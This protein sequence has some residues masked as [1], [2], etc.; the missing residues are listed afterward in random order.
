MN[1]TWF[2]WLATIVIMT[3]LVINLLGISL[4][5]VS[6]GIGGGGWAFILMGV[7]FL[8]AM[9]SAIVMLFRS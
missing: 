2:F 6:M 1:S 5:L 8:F 7:M 4:A 9:I 3:A